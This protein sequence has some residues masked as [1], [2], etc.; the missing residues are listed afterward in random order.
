MDSK[1]HGIKLIEKLVDS[2]RQLREIVSL[3]PTRQTC[4]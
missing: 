1:Y 3:Y 2:N 4:H